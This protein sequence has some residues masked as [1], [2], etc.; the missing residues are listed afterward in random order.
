MT[1]WRPPIVYP[2]PVTLD[3]QAMHP[4]DLADVLRPPHW[5]ARRAFLTDRE[6]L[7]IQ[8]RLAGVSWNVLAGELGVSRSTVRSA[9]LSARRKLAMR[10][11]EAT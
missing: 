4:V 8:A 10:I 9:W 11:E 7:V 5:P 2:T 3:P 6:V 1:D